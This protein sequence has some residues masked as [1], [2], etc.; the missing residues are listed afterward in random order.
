MRLKRM[1]VL[2]GWSHSSD[3]ERPNLL[4]HF[5]GAPFILAAAT[6]GLAFYPDAT[7][8]GFVLTVL[9]TFTVYFPMTAAVLAATAPHVPEPALPRRAYLSLLAAWSVTAWVATAISA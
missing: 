8:A 1:T 9:A 2:T 5:A 6:P 3:G 4:T 7:V